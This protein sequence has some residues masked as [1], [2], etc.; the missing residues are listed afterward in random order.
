MDGDTMTNRTKNGIGCIIISA[1]LAGIA[2]KNSFFPDGISPTDPS[3]LGV[4]RLVGSFLPAILVLALGVWL[5][6]KPKA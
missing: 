1:V 4:S 3:G 6:Q 5:M 2:V